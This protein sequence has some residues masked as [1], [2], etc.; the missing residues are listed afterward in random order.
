MRCAGCGHEN[1][2]GKFC[3]ECGARLQALCPAC[4]ATNPPTN[5]FCGECGGPLTAPPSTATAARTEAPVVPGPD[6]GAAA[7]P[8]VTSPQSPYRDASPATYTP[9]HLAEKILATKGAVQG[10]RKNVTVMFVDVC[11]FTTISEKLDPEDVHGIMDRAFAVML[12]AVHRYEGNIN[13][14]LGD[15]IMALFGAPIAHEDH[16]HRAL[17]ASLGIREGLKPLQEDVR[18]TYGVEFRVRM[19]LN[20]GVVVVGAIGGDLRMDYTAVG[21]T[22]NL[23]ARLMSLAQPGQ[24]MVSLRTQHLREQFFRWEDL[25]QFQVKGK[26]EP[27]HAY[28]LLDE[29]R[30][31]TRLEVSKERGLTPLIGREREVASLVNMYRR[32]EEGHGAVVLVSGEPGVGKSRLLYEFLRAI[33]TGGGLELEA[34]CVAYGRTIPYRPIL[35]LVRGYLSLLEEMTGDEVRWRAEKGLL[36]LGIEGEEPATLLAHFLGVPAPE[37]FLTRLGGSQIKERTFAVLR[38]VLVRV[39]DSAPLV[40]TVENIHWIDATSEEFLEQLASHVPNHRIVLLFTTRPGATPSA[41]AERAE[42]T[43]ALGGLDGNELRGMVANLA[44]AEKVS[45]ELFRILLDKSAGNPLYIEEILRQLQETDGLTA[46]EG[47]VRLRSAG[48]TVPETIHDII[49]ARIDRVADELKRVL[50]GAAVIGRRFGVS[51]LSRVLGVPGEP[52]THQLAELHRLDFIFPAGDDP[53]LMYSFKHALT[54][55]VVYGSVLERRRREYHAAAGRGLEE[56][57]AGRTDEVV[58]LL[59]YHFGR[60]AEAEKAVDYDIAAAAKAQRR[61]ANAEALSHF[62]AAVKR[63][64]TMPDTEA[65]RLRRIDAVVKQAEV[66]FALGRHAQHIQALEAIHDLVLAVADPPRRAAWYYWTGFLHSIAGGRS[67]VP[68]DY[69]REAAAIADAHGFEEIKALAECGLTHLYGMA[70]NLRDAL[71]AGEQ[72]LATFEARGNVW[73]SCRTLFGLI[74]AAIYVGDWARSLEYC[75]RALEHGEAV[76]DHRLK[77]VGWWR[78]GWTHIQRGDLENGLRCCEEALALE[79]SPFD[80]AMARS[81]H[82]YGLVKA[83]KDEAGIAELEEAVAWFKQSKL[84]RTRLAFAV[85]L[86]DAYC[87]LGDRSRARMIAEDV[88]AGSQDAGYRNLEGMAARILG[89]SLLLEDPRAA[90]RHLEVALQILD[91]VEALNEAAKVLVAQAA[92]ATAENDHS[93][94]REKLQR[95]LTIFENL[96]TLDEITRVRA[97]L[98]AFENSSPV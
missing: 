61:W 69:C 68:I 36:A 90:A 29:I 9:K 95:A 48:V 19:G 55:D 23:T 80:A 65:N 63:L 38:D 34:S 50:Q 91:E 51:L 16:P 44:H 39:S 72:A 96:G 11:G 64:E 40:L 86:G 81:A 10:E 18:R 92:L 59:A 74:I 32:A 27:V 31:R 66:M 73:W 84:E 12:E 45:E 67:E 94:G 46:V 28:A 24:I 21:D 54:Q 49:A 93:T 75:R 57:Y 14:F 33:E 37:A 70:G 77:V 6:R 97:T 62:E 76:N 4:Q 89:E 41:L 26:S 87:R 30:G 83:G 25:G 17:S 98:A 78:T 15:G 43:L 3:G 88:L 58:E 35:D 8:P 13:Q 79:P 42:T 60:S 85:W 20:T 53:E 71:E 5:K 7:P 82:G 47:E 56:L 22:T 52:I 2:T 1:P